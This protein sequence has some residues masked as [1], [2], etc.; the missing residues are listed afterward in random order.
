MADR[1]CC[2]REHVSA[3]TMSVAPAG[4]WSL[5]QWKFLTV[6]DCCSQKIM[7]PI[8]WSFECPA[9][10]ALMTFYPSPFIAFIRIDALMKSVVIATYS[11]MIQVLILSPNLPCHD[12]VLPCIQALAMLRALPADAFI[13]RQA[14]AP[15]DDGSGVTLC[16]VPADNGVDKAAVPNLIPPVECDGEAILFVEDYDHTVWSVTEKH[17]RFDIYARTHPVHGG[18]SVS[19]GS[20]GRH[21]HGSDRSGPRVRNDSSGNSGTEGSDSGDAVAGTGAVSLGAGRSGGHYGNNSMANARHLASRAAGSSTIA[22]TASAE[23]PQGGAEETTKRPSV[24]RTIPNRGRTHRP[25]PTQPLSSGSLEEKSV[26]SPGRHAAGSLTS[27][28]GSARSHAHRHVS[29]RVAKWGAS[30]GWEA[31]STAATGLGPK[32]RPFRDGANPFVLH[33]AG[34]HGNAVDVYIKA[35]WSHAFPLALRRANAVHVFGQPWKSLAMPA[36]LPLTSDVNPTES[37]LE[38]THDVNGYTI[39]FMNRREDD[40]HSF[41]RMVDVRISQ[42]FQYCHHVNSD[43]DK[44]ENTNDHQMCK[45]VPGIRGAKS[46]NRFFESKKLN[47]PVV[48]DVWLSFGDTFHKLTYQKHDR[49]VTVRIFKPKSIRGMSDNTIMYQQCSQFN[50]AWAVESASFQASLAK[51]RWNFNDNLVAEGGNISEKDETRMLR[52]WRVRYAL[53]PNTSSDTHQQFELLLQDVNRIIGATSTTMVK[54]TTPAPPTTALKNSPITVLQCREVSRPEAHEVL[55]QKSVVDIGA[56]TKSDTG[57]EEVVIVRYDSHFRVN[58]TFHIE[59]QWLEA[60]SYVVDAF[61]DR[62]VKRAE[63]RGFRLVQVCLSLCG[64]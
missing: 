49:M 28:G 38:T 57:K 25:T 55:A 42:C 34:T 11:T 35:R 39:L 31:G 20:I 56:S 12:D 4:V 43:D 2:A 17:K 46:R 27:G 33:E 32:T 50:D 52:F 64:R 47:L 37:S 9:L 16:G 26:P 24:P 60:T 48:K 7:L 15:S 13:A 40:D 8:R 1:A 36:M 30:R 63:S 61:T 22:R 29:S 41:Q 53:T 3:K 14:T 44:P 59:V 18:G 45:L 54:E 23:F 19:G 51:F 62:W 10:S 5:S 58:R 6:S 21:H